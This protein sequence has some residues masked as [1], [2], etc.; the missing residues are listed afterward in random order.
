MCDEERFQG[1]NGLNIVLEGRAMNIRL[2]QFSAKP[3][4]DGKTINNISLNASRINVYREPASGVF[5][6]GFYKLLPTF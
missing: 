2:C 4:E 3:H 6:S 5:K 1:H